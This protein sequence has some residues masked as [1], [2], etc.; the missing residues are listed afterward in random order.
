MTDNQLLIRKQETIRYMLTEFIKHSEGYS[1]TTFWMAIKI[2]NDI[3]EETEKRK[4][5]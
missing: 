4:D 2:C 3:Y 5:T 1:P